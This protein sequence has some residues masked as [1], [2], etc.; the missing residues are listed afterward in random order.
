M[1]VCAC[2]CVCARM[3]ESQGSINWQKWS[4]AHR[5]QCLLLH[6]PAAAAAAVTPLICIGRVNH[7]HQYCTAGWCFNDDN[8]G[9][10]VHLSDLVARLNPIRKCDSNSFSSIVERRLVAEAKST[11]TI[12]ESLTQCA[13]RRES[14]GSGLWVSNDK[15]KQCKAKL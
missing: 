9:A 6:R 5:I 8:D 2:V 13:H 15:A 7:I 4:I 3:G 12:S 11:N 1:C 10:H 14:R